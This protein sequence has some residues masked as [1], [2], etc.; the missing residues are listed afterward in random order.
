[1]IM[2]VTKEIAHV[3]FDDQKLPR[4]EETLLSLVR[5]VDKL[6]VQSKQ[7]KNENDIRTLASLVLGVAA[8]DQ[9][10]TLV[11]HDSGV[12]SVDGDH[13]RNKFKTVE[14]PIFNG[15]DLDSWLFQA[16]RY[17]QIHKLTHSEQLT[18]AVIVL[19]QQHLIGI[20]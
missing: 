1:M 6:M 16:D 18:V 13:D 10:Y 5:S 20:E 8:R 9:P 4:I 2:I 3:R 7:G 12:V 19:K 11:A 15:V 17:F 14:M